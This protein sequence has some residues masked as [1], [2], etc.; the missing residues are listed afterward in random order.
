MRKDRPD[1]AMTVTAHLR[2]SR[3]AEPDNHGELPALLI[4]EREMLG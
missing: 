3:A 2:E 1:G 4:L